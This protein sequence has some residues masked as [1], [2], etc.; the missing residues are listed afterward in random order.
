MASASRGSMVRSYCC[1]TAT[2]R[3]ANQQA[4]WSGI[5][6]ATSF[7]T[8]FMLLIRIVD[9]LPPQGLLE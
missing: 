8:S 2:L 1:H 7:A 9:D 4:L 5:H 3:A 6:S